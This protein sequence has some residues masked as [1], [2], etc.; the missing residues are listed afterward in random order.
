MPGELENSLR[1]LI[2]S[3]YGE[4]KAFAAHAGIPNSTLDSMFK[5]GYP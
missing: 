4:M 1:E 5:R 3:R 2:K